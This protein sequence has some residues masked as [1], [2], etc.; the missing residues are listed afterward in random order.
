MTKVKT[1]LYVVYKDGVPFKLSG[2]KNAVYH[3]VGKAK[4]R[5]T[6]E[7]NAL[8]E[9]VAIERGVQP[10]DPGYAVFVAKLAKKARD[11]FSIMEY[12]PTR[13]VLR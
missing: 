9:R 5:I 12:G 8:A 10:T 6:T 7:V 11:R 4:S 3:H 1:E 13:E 2:T